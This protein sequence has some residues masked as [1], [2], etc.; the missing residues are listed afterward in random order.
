MDGTFRRIKQSRD[1][2]LAHREGRADRLGTMVFFPR[3]Q[4]GWKVHLA[5]SGS[6][7]VCLS[8]I[9]GLCERR[10]SGVK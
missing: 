8:F 10:E 2:I 7:D 1:L 9:L 5:P 6:E 3:T 4:A